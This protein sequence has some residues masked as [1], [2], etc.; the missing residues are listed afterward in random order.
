MGASG[1]V[2]YIKLLGRSFCHIILVT[3]S[4]GSQG[5]CNVVIFNVVPLNGLF[6]FYWGNVP[7][8]NVLIFF[9]RW[10]KLPT[11]LSGVTRG[12]VA[13]DQLCKAP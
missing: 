7:M 13:S 8:F 4:H 6:R 5:N 2:T 9:V 10:R 3:T 1:H 11:P 12:P